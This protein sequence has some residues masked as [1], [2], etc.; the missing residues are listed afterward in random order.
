[1]QIYGNFEGFLLY[2]CIVGKKGMLGKDLQVDVF[3]YLFES[4]VIS[5]KVRDPGFFVR[6]SVEILN[7]PNV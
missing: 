5:W 2:Q 6:G 1:M 7:P 3:S 4:G